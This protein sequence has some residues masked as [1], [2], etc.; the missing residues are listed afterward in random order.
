[1]ICISAAPCFVAG[2]AQLEA[3]TINGDGLTSQFRTGI[4]A[5]LDIIQRVDV[6]EVIVLFR[7]GVGRER[8]GD[9]FGAFTGVVGPGV[10]ELIRIGMGRFD[11]GRIGLVQL[12]QTKLDAAV[13]G[14]A[15]LRNGQ[16]KLTASLKRILCDEGQCVRKF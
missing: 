5:N 14:I 9:A 7:F 10:I 3:C 2:Q 11:H 12:D 4:L 6:D 16:R 13:V 15:I 8:D 1:M